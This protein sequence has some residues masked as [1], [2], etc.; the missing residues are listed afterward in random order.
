M[1]INIT[2]KF[3]NY[4]YNR[5]FYCLFLEK[6]MPALLKI[7]AIMLCAVLIACGSSSNEENELPDENIP[8][9]DSD[10]ATPDGN[11]EDPNPVSDTDSAVEENDEDENS[12]ADSPENDSETP[13]DDSDPEELQTGGIY[14]FSDFDGSGNAQSREILGNGGFFGFS[15]MTLSDKYWA[16]SA[17]HESIPAFDWDKAT[18][19]LYI[20]E[21]EKK[22]EKLE[23]AAFVLNH[24]EKSI[25]VGFGYAA[26]ELCD[27][28]GDGFDD[29]AVSSHLATFNN[30]SAAGEIVVFYGGASGWKEENSSVSRLSSEY[31]QK[32][33]SMSQSLA[34]LDYDGDGFADVFAGGQ[35]A[36]PELSGGGSQGM[37]AMFKGSA[38]GLSEHENSVLLPEVEEKAQYFGSGMI[39]YDFN[40]DSKPDLV[41]AGWGLK[42]NSSSANS[43]GVYIYLGGENWFAGASEKIF[44]ETETQFGSALKI[45]EIGGKKY[46]AVL[47]PKD[48]NYGTVN[49]YDPAE[50]FDARGRFSFPSA[51]VEEGNLSDFDTIKISADTDLIVVGGKTFSS[52]GMTY[53]A[54][55]KNKTVS[56]AE[57]CKFQPETPEGGFG[58]SVKNIGNGEIV[59]GKPEYIHRF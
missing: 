5:P 28:N 19:K 38:A 56:E 35:N 27:I 21:K 45:I 26:T 53:C 14:I 10:T 29:I 59:V 17:I 11:D 47:A 52:G 49:F 44:G 32:A 55:I 40:G 57:A 54:T 8:A 13:G 22:V 3:F 42:E 58:Y 4:I 23:D 7:L 39:V 20:F 6:T 46:L 51:F 1:E 30:L 2:V 37:V 36:G 41:V 24:P 15:I 25:N 50:N 9:D 33:D 12:D 43:G 48:K 31:I 18:G 34:C 16:V